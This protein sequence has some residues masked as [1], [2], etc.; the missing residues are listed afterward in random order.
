MRRI[1]FSDQSKVII[2]RLRIDGILE[3]IIISLTRSCMASRELSLN[4][5]V[6]L[7]YAYHT[8]SIDSAT[9]NK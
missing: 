2:A 3:R 8:R 4:T 9:Y 1:S 5:L 6:G 7:S